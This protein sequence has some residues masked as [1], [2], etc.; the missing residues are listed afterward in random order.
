MKVP[1]ISLPYLYTTKDKLLLAAAF[2]LGIPFSIWIL[3][4]FGIRFEMSDW[5]FHRLILGYGIVAAVSILIN[6][7][8]VK[9]LVFGIRMEK[10]WNT[11]SSL[12]WYSWHLVVVVVCSFLWFLPFAMAVDYPLDIGLFSLASRILVALLIPVVIIWAFGYKLRPNQPLNGLTLQGLNCSSKLKID[13]N[14]FLFAQAADN[15]VEI[16]LLRDGKMEK[17]LLRS[18]LMHLEDQLKNWGMVRCHRSIIVNPSKI[19]M[20]VGRKRERKIIFTELDVVIP[21]SRRYEHRFNSY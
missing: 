4:P 14:S 17:I 2:G 20:T 12:L 18:T 5:Y 8:G 9:A 16:C 11:V 21:V 10:T 3:Q 15:Y 7:F 19:S 1:N 6:E 13:L